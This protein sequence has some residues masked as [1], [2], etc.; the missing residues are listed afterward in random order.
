MSP[1]VRSSPLSSRSPAR[2][3]SGLLTGCARSRKDAMHQELARVHREREHDDQEWGA[4]LYTKTE[5]EYEETQKLSIRGK[6]CKKCSNYIADFRNSM[7]VFRKYLAE[8]GWDENH[9]QAKL[10]KFREYPDHLVCKCK[11]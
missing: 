11:R 3:T 6:N 1:S 2:G 9:P 4:T 10:Y 8:Y 7:A 5:E